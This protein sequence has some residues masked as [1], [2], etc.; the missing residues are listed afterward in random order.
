MSAEIRRDRVNLWTA[1]VS[2]LLTCEQG[3]PRVGKPEE[4]GDDDRHGQPAQYG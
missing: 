3:R 4:V 1:A 2:G